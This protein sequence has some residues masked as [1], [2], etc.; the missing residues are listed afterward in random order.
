MLQIVANFATV[1]GRS[2]SEVNSQGSPRSG[3][4][5][6]HPKETLLDPRPTS[7]S[8]S[9]TVTLFSRN[10]CSYFM[11]AL[12]HNSVVQAAIASFLA[13]CGSAGMADK[14][15]AACATQGISCHE[16]WLNAHVVHDT[17]S[18]HDHNHPLIA[19]ITVDRISVQL[20]RTQ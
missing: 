1:T 18:R 16:N 3:M 4:A 13:A 20:G 7:I 5:E 11:Q 2:H 8:Y 17:I 12:E 14:V 19:R 6:E 15:L 9:A 10:T